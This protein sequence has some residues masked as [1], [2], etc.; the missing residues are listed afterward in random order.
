MIFSPDS[1]AVGI[2]PARLSTDT[3]FGLSV[4]AVPPA[5]HLSPR[6]LTEMTGSMAGHDGSGGKS[7]S[8]SAVM[9]L[10]EDRQIIRL[11][12]A[13]QAIPDHARPGTL[14]RR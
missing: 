6:V 12:L 7:Q 2:I 5:F 3:R 13:W 10:V 1:P 4:M 8:L 9:S 14:V 11:S